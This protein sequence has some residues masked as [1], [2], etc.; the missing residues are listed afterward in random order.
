MRKNL[1]ALAACAAGGAIASI[2]HLPLPWMIG[3]LLAMAGCRFAGQDIRA[4]AF[5]RPAGQVIIGT[6]LGLYF[7]PQ[8]VRQ[9]IDYAP[10]MAAA[11]M[12]AML[13]GY[14]SS[15]ILARGAGI[16]GTTAFFA[17][18]PG[19]A[20]EM[21]V[22]AERF[23]A[24]VDQVAAGQ[25]VRIALVVI[26][27]PAV[28][29]YG[30]LAGVDAYEQT[31][32]LVEP[33]GLLGLLA[34]GTAGGLL[35]RM[36]NVPNGFTIGALIASIALTIEGANWSAMPPVLS[37]AGQL[38]IGCALGSRFEQDFLER[39]PRFLAALFA[40]IFA[41]MLISVMFGLGL[42]GLLH[43]AWPTLV[44]ATAPGGIAEMA[45]TAKVLR[46]GVPIVTAFHV[47]R[48]IMLVTLTAPAFGIARAIANRRDD[49][50]T[51]QRDG[52]HR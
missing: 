4:P 33:L 50:P 31:Q 48:M 16:D 36:V 7:T 23:G 34:A 20:A 47:T 28:F 10:V 51:R 2:A 29:L 21:S 42:A 32:K 27:F 37:N 6:A 45:I 49:K 8:V 19:G 43:G 26:V 1:L 41:A 38:L 14:L 12:F 24:K 35:L 13:T 25:S 44:L 9:V 18:V 40:S 46:L 22:L 15:L 17:S 5:A 39:A 11:G 52:E 3:P 30:G